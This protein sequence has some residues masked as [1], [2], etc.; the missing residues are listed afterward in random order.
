MGHH[1]RHGH[2]TDEDKDHADHLAILPR[3]PQRRFAYA[4]D[5]VEEGA[6]SNVRDLKKHKSKK[7]DEGGAR[8]VSTKKVS[9][10]SAPEHPDCATPLVISTPA[11]TP[12]PT[13]QCESASFTTA[14]EDYVGGNKN[15][16]VKFSFTN[17]ID[18]VFNCNDLLDSIASNG[19][20]ESVLVAYQNNLLMQYG[21]SDEISYGAA[22]VTDSCIMGDSEDGACIDSIE[23]ICP[24]G[25]ERQ[26]QQSS[27]ITSATVR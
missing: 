19:S 15:G 17:E 16:A 1:V 12:A 13:D 5:I 3:G 4:P 21:C 8:L 6:A 18:F 14:A 23:D 20:I 11:P 9:C 26:L 27:S 25:R 7:S 10:K 2:E 24:S 22:V